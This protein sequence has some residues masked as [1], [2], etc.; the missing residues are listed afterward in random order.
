MMEMF[1]G[2][3]LPVI[4]GGMLKTIRTMIGIRRNPS[5]IKHHKIGTAAEE[6]IAWHGIECFQLLKV[7]QEPSKRELNCYH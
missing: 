3:V 5:Q 1:I 4:I 2:Y 6:V 7:L